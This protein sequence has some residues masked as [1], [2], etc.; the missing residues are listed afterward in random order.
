MNSED[1]QLN[2]PSIVRQINFQYDS[3]DVIK[4]RERIRF[5]LLEFYIT[6]DNDTTA[7]SEGSRPGE[8]VLAVTD[9]GFFFNVYHKHWIC[10]NDLLGWRVYSFLNNQMYEIEKGGIKKEIEAK[11]VIE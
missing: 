9:D 4:S 1:I 6:V 10:G 3:K 2:L 8:V 5:C 11:A 7:T